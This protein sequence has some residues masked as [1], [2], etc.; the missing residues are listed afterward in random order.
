MAET[1][2]KGYHVAERNQ[3]RYVLL[4]SWTA[5]LFSLL[6]F[7]IFNL[8]NSSPAFALD[9]PHGTYLVN[10]HPRSGYYRSDGTYVSPTMVSTYCRGFGLSKELELKFENKMPPQWPYK[11][12]HFKKWSAQEQVK[13][14]KFFDSLPKWL[15]QVG[16]LRLPR[17]SKSQVQGNPASCE[18]EENV[19]VLYDSAFKQNT[20]AI[21]A[22]ELGHIHFE[23]LSTDEKNSFYKVSGW[24]KD[25]SGQY[26]TSNTVFS[27]PD[28]ALSPQEDFANNL[29]IFVTQPQKLKN[30]FREISNWFEQHYGGQK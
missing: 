27:L 4:F 19:I 10:G 30:S 13:L 5:A 17:A 7:I 28:G 9:C 1:L 16:K 18:P 2:I 22:H 12:E 6:L 25:R 15:T 26:I 21:L 8:F 24:Q 20:V 29:E 3:E 11:K 23:Y 14:K